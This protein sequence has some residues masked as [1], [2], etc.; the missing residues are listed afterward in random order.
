MV[1]RSWCRGDGH[2]RETAAHGTSVSLGMPGYITDFE[3]QDGKERERKVK[4]G[5][6]KESRRKIR[7]EDHGHTAER[8]FSQAFALDES[9]QSEKP[10]RGAS[11]H[12]GVPARTVVPSE[13]VLEEVER[14]AA[15]VPPSSSAFQLDDAPDHVEVQGRKPNRVP[16]VC[17]P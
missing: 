13:I 17:F 9:A 11:S 6:W 2:V 15:T 16:L 12:P 10:R 4:R 14:A 8:S 3:L 5:R 7:V 1:L